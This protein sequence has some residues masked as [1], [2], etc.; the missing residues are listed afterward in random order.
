MAR[1]RKTKARQPAR[2]IPLLEDW[3]VSHNKTQT[4][5]ANGLGTTRQ[6]VS[7]W[8]VGRVCPGLYYA[9][10][11]E[12]VTDGAVPLEAWL[13]DEHAAALDALRS[14]S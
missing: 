4:D 11:I 8:I 1:P 2:A 12:E 3:L 10:L 5:L 13:S 7:G 14:K 9:L 6:A